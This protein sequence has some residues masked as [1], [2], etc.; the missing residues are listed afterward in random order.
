MSLVKTCTLLLVVAQIILTASSTEAQDSVRPVRLLEIKA[1]KNSIPLSLPL[2]VE[3]AL[4]TDLTF[5][6]G[7]VIEELFVKEGQ[8]IKEGDLIARLDPTHLEN[9]LKQETTKLNSAEDDFRR[10]E[11]LFKS[12]TVSQVALDRAKTQ[13]KLA[14]LTVDDAMKKLEQSYMLAPFDAAV[15]SVDVKPFQPVSPATQIVRLQSLEN[16]EA[17]VKIPAT[18]GINLNSLRVGKKTIFLDIIPFMSVSA[19]FL[20]YSPQV[21]VAT[22]THRAAFGFEPPE[23]LAVLGGMTGEIRLQADVVSGINQDVPE[24]PLSAVLHDGN[25]NYVFKVDTESM[26]VS[27]Q[28]VQIDQ[29][30]G[31][32]LPVTSGLEVG[33]TVVGAGAA[34][35]KDG[36]SIRRLSE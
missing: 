21:E 32:I 26:I 17:I 28:V 3:P 30:I 23:G 35:L 9:R 33:D 12:K 8:N 16:F 36:Q 29:A 5:Q 27:K 11:I 4:V 34:Y 1:Q 31:S 6:V 20:R 25:K 13:V 2:V 15:A 7:G 14:Q 18:R 22:Q 24:V 10:S 19:E